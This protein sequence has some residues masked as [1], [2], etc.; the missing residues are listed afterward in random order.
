MVHDTYPSKSESAPEHAMLM[1]GISIDAANREALSSAALEI[2][3]G[4][5][6]VQAVRLMRMNGMRMRMMVP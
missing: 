4:L 3:S 6:I 1:T 2:F 5:W